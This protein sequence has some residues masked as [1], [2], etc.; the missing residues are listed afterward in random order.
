[1]LEEEEE[2]E[3]EDECSHL[4]AHRGVATWPPLGEPLNEGGCYRQDPHEQV[5]RLYSQYKDGLASVCQQ[6]EKREQ[7]IHEYYQRKEQQWQRQTGVNGPPMS[8]DLTNVWLAEMPRAPPAQP[9]LRARDFQPAQTDCEEITD[10][11]GIDP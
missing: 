10:L 4:C 2:N 1:M 5:E 11:M 9:P 6:Q 3:D 7:E 8:G